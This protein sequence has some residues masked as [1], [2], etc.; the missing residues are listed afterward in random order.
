MWDFTHL[1]LY[2]DRLGNTRLVYAHA[3]VPTAWL[4]SPSTSFRIVQTFYC[5]PS[6]WPLITAHPF[7]GSL[8]PLGTLWHSTPLT[9]LLFLWSFLYE[10]FARILFLCPPCT[11]WCSLGS[12]PWPSSQSVSSFWMISP[13]LWLQP[14][15]VL[16]WIPTLF[17]RV[18]IPYF[19]QGQQTHAWLPR[20]HVHRCPQG[21]LVHSNLNLPHFVP[22]SLNPFSP[23]LF[24]IGMN[25][26]PLSYFPK[27]EM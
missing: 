21:S 23:A 10:F 22:L 11:H 6:L 3:E 15:L 27:L 18:Q 26:P 4:L 24:L 20:V 2:S 7:L 1:S 16:G 9:F 17:L 14:W 12:C 13:L 8:S 19:S 25:I 5:L